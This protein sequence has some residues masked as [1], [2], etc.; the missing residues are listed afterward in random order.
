MDISKLNVDQELFLGEKIGEIL[1][2][3]FKGKP[4]IQVMDLDV[5]KALFDYLEL[6]ACCDEIKALLIKEAPYQNETCGIYRLLQKSA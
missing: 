3:S 2:L 5:K 4:L 1:M 6:V